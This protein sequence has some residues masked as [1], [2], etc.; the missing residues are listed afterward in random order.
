MSLHSFLRSRENLVI[1][2]LLQFSVDVFW[3]LQVT[4]RYTFGRS[5]AAATTCTAEKHPSRCGDTTEITERTLEPRSRA[6]TPQHTVGSVLTAVYSFCRQHFLSE[7][8]YRVLDS[9]I[10]VTEMIVE[11][12]IIGHR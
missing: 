3:R 4:W 6:R 10:L 12:E 9:D 7:Q 11:M 5:S 1:D 2:C 8:S